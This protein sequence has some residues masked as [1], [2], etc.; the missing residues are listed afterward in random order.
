VSADDSSLVLRTPAG[1]GESR[2]A[3]RGVR[4]VRLATGTREGLGIGVGALLGG[5]ILGGYPALAGEGFSPA[6]LLV[7]ATV[8]AGIGSLLGSRIPRHREYAPEGGP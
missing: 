3:R 6:G 4:R 8:G 5:G 1:D 2:F 7:G